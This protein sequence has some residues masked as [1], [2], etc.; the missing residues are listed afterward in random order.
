M[1]VYKYEN[2]IDLDLNF[3]LLDINPRALKNNK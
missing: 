1:V 3:K 2:K